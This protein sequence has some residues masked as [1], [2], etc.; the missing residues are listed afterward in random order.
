MTHVVSRKQ[1]NQIKTWELS[2]E[3]QVLWPAT[4]FENSNKKGSTNRL[5]IF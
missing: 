3:R 1:Y 2:S 5:Y 4:S